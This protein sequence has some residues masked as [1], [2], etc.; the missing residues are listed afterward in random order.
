MKK[1]IE[2]KNFLGFLGLLILVYLIYNIGF[3]EI[4]LT[5]IN[6]KIL[7]LLISLPFLFLCFAIWSYRL[8]YLLDV[9]KFNLNFNYVLKMYFIGN[10][11]STITPSQ[12]GG[13]IMKI[14]YIRKETSRTLTETASVVILDKILEIITLLILGIVGIFV[15][16]EYLSIKLF[17][18]IILMIVV[19]ILILILLVKK[20][21]G[22]IF[23][24]LAY[25]FVVPK[26]IKEKAKLSFESFYQHL[27]T[28]KILIL[29][30]ILAILGW[31]VL[32]SFAYFLGFSL[33]IEISYPIFIIIMAIGSL[34]G[35]LPISFGGL[36]T[37]EGT[38]VFLLG[39]FGVVA[40]QSF[41]LSIS[42]YVIAKFFPAL[43][44]LILVF[45]NKK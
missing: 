20:N 6:L 38:V 21:W 8:K 7:F 36:G 29:P 41:A 33:G 5:F 13:V 27:F 4:I 26:N 28:N 42:A 34:V 32:Y 31:I 9:K 12:I 11:Y 45:N 14:F 2:I 18:L 25:K 22:E 30:F 44:G 24:R 3:R 23:F 10:F 17:L 16:F 39:L 35:L 37:R 40:S 1:I 19:F 15:L 43:V